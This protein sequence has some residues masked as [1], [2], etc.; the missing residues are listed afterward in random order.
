MNTMQYAV[1][2][3]ACSILYNWSYWQNIRYWFRFD[4]S[5]SVKNNYKYKKIKCMINTNTIQQ[6]CSNKKCNYNLPTACRKTVSL[7]S[8]K[9]KH[10]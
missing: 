6:V 10:L 8:L 2:L 3:V 5:K 7:V 4:C 1:L 9:I